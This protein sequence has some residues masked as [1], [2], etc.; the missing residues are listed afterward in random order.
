MYDLNVII[1]TGMSGAGKSSAMHILEDMG[2][3]C[4]D[5]FP[6]DLISELTDLIRDSENSVYQ[7]LAL[8]VNIQDYKEVY[9]FLS[10]R[11]INTKGLIL[12]ANNDVILRRYKFTRR[13]HP[14][15]LSNEATTLEEAIEKERDI[16]DQANYQKD[17]IIDTSCLS[18]KELGNRIE[19][20]FMIGDHERFSISFVSFGYKYGIPDDADLTFDVRFLPNPYWDENLR[21]LTGDDKAVY[22]YVIDNPETQTFLAELENFLDYLLPQYKN[23]GKYHLTIGIGCTGGQHRSVSI[24]NYLYQ[25]YGNKYHCYKGHRDKKGD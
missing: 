2:Y 23:N 16:F 12:N 3:L 19:S 15:L 24:V 10:N 22:D 4:I 5:K 17:L 18:N 20:Y 14:L 7:N 13:T 21:Q 8:S 6:V 25:L 9:N 1:V 11:G